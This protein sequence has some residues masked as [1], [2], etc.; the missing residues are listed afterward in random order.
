MIEKHFKLVRDE[1]AKIEWLI[2]QKEIESEYDE[3]CT[4]GI[5][6]GCLSFRDGSIFHFKELFIDE[7]RRYR[8]HYMDMKNELISRWDNAPHH[9]ALVTF[10]HHV[11]FSDGIKESASVGF[12]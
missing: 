5:I 10:P 1:I 8:L 3:D 9:R 11:H 7:V 12:V 4:F 6:G 2:E